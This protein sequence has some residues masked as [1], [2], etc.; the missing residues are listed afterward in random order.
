MAD[1]KTYTTW[2]SLPDTLTAVHISKILGIS[3]RRIYELFKIHVDHG[4][5]PNFEIGISK[6]VEKSDLI[7]WVSKRKEKKQSVI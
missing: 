5:I 3:R 2:D 1:K 7:N 4:G 6:R